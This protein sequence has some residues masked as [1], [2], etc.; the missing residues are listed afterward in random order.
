MPEDPKEVFVTLLSEVRQN[1]E[2]AAEL[3]KELAEM[4]QDNPQIKEL[5]EARAFLSAKTLE[6]LDHCFK[7]IGARP[8]IVRGRLHEVFVEELRKGLAEIK[9]PI[10][11]HLFLLAKL[12][13]F[14]HIRIGEFEALIAADMTGH[15]G[16]GALLEGAKAAKVAFVER[17]RRLMRHFVEAK[18]AERKIA[19]R[20]A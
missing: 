8:V 20:A 13:H 10:A 9:S 12:A 18:V 6:H 4:A 3:H 17:N 16:V 2:K 11:R 7:L 5:I 19:E 14:N 1:T 15:Q